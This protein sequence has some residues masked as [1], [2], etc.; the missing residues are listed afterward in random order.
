MFLGQLTQM[1]TD[2][3]KC[4]LYICVSRHINVQKYTPTSTL[5]N[6]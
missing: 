4:K 2:V 1:G 3:E 5:G 6:I